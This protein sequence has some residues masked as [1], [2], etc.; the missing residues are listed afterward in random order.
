[1]TSSKTSTRP[2]HQRAEPIEDP[3]TAEA[4]R[5]TEKATLATLGNPDHPNFAQE[6]KLLAEMLE[7]AEWAR[8]QPDEKLKKLFAYI[9][10]QH[11]RRRRFQVDR[12]ELAGTATAFSS[13]PNTTT[14]SRTSGA[15]SRPTS[16]RRMQPTSD[17]PSTKDRLRSKRR[18]EIKE[19]FN[20]DPAVNP[21]RI[22]LATDAAREG[23]NL[24]KYCFNLFHYDI[25]WNPARLEQR[26][27]RIDRKLQPAPTVYCRYFLYENREEDAILR[28]IVEK[29]ENIYREL[30]GFG[31]VLDK[32]LVQTLRRRG[33][34]RSRLRD[35]IQML[36]FRDDEEDERAALALAEVSGDDDDLGDDEAGQP[37][38]PKESARER[39]DRR[40]REKLRKEPRSA[41]Q[42]HGGEPP[43]AR[44][45]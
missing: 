7:M 41:S 15:S 27:G 2:T 19:A 9:D 32:N 35:T 1:M 13:S 16:N 3:A 31:T 10:R 20:A 22:L 4:E 28:R 44:F 23:L 36:D 8:H 42:D 39:I 25:P 24:Q 26:N 33:I 34:E 6:M 17:W 37:S 11:A 21:V 45:P 40:R 14:R 12:A 38:A 30:G 29:T 18:Q 43:L 5:Q